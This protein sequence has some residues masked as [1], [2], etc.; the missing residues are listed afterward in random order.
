MFFLWYISCLLLII[1]SFTNEQLCI[2]SRSFDHN[3]NETL[4]L[5]YNCTFTQRNQCVVIL[6]F[7]YTTRI[8]KHKF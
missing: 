1:N 3:F 6:T 7:N 5:L 4:I 8:V 2:Y